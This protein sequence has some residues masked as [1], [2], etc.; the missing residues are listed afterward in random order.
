MVLLARGMAGLQETQAIV[1]AKAPAVTVHLVQADLSDLASLPTIFSKVLDVADTSK[2]EQFFLIH[3]AGTI[4]DLSKP[5]IS[6]TNPT[7]IQQHFGLNYTSVFLLT[8]LFLSR[9]KSGQ[10]TVVN[11]TS[12]ASKSPIES[13]ALYCSSRAARES[14]MRVLAVENP[15]VR[16]L[17]YSPGPCDTDMFHGISRDTFS[18]QVRKAFEGTTPLTCEESIAKLVCLLSK[19]EFESGCTIDYYD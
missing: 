3:N 5:L 2:H 19:D 18:E 11:I 8:S 4:G 1:A 12:I 17:N 14:L 10:R 9:F 15:A 13:C 7:E 16:V 6:H